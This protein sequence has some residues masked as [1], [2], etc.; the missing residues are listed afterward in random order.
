MNLKKLKKSFGLIFIVLS[1]IFML[2][3]LFK[4]D[5][6]VNLFK[7][8]NKININY[9][10]I[11]FLY[12]FIFWFLEAAMIYALIIKQRNSNS[13]KQVFTFSDWHN[14]LFILSCSL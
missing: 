12:I 11:A 13:Y 7:V 5:D 9:I 1:A 6:L 8:I 10:I 2:I 4:N 3:I 14:H